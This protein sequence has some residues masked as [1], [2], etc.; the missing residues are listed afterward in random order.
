MRSGGASAIVD[1]PNRLA[2]I[3]HAPGRSQF[4]RKKLVADGPARHG[5]AFVADSA[6]QGGERLYGCSL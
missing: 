5:A 6:R 4:D 2:L 1:P 3:D